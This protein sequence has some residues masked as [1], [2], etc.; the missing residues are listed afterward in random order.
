[1]EILLHFIAFYSPDKYKEIQRKTI[2]RQL[3]TAQKRHFEK[4]AAKNFQSK[5]SGETING[6]K[7]HWKINK[8]SLTTVSAGDFIAGFQCHT[9]QNRSK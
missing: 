1:M 7:C 3:K 9:I 6:G 5:I 4:N 8:S 2:R